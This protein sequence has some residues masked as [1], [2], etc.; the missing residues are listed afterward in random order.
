MPLPASTPS[1]PWWLPYRLKR[2][3]TFRRQRRVIVRGRD[4][5][6]LTRVERRI[7]AEARAAA[8]EI[9]GRH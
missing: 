9:M 8:D 1:G 4:G 3:L 5:W 7:D 2:Y 6:G